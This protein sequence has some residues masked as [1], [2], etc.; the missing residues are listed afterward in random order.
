[1]ADPL[2][3]AGLAAGVVSL[4]LQVTGGLMS[5][6]DA[7]RSREEDLALAKQYSGSIQ[8]AINQIDSSPS[9]TQASQ[10]AS[11]SIKASV[12]ACKTQLKALED[13]V[14]KLSSAPSS[15]ATLRSKLR[16][17]SKKLVYAFH[18]SNIK[19]LEDSLSR[20]N[21]TLQGAMQ[22]LGLSVTD[23]VLSWPHR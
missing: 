22:A 7:I 17:N 2:S 8:A 19:E 21:I 12:D 1:M 10:R 4:G 11:A 16:D 20:A 18:R 14:N 15:N 3:V 6:L 5:Y 13:L 23:F 9:C